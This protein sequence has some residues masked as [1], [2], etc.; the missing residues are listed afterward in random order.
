VS[1]SWTAAGT[2]THGGE[3]SGVQR[4]GAAGAV[5]LV[6]A[7]HSFHDARCPLSAAAAAAVCALFDSHTQAV[8]GDN[9]LLLTPPLPRPSTHTAPPPPPRR[10]PL[11]GCAALDGALPQPAERHHQAGG[12]HHQ[13]RRQP[14]GR[15]HERHLAPQ[16]TRAVLRGGHRPGE[17]RGGQSTSSRGRG[18]GR[19]Y[20]EDCLRGLGVWSNGWQVPGRLGGDAGGVLLS[21]CWWQAPLHPLACRLVSRPCPACVCSLSLVC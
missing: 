4:C 12:Q 14:P 8:P 18:L 6:V 13:L 16:P 15:R 3:S 5:V 20:A 1:S 2:A 11:P 10:R 7:H 21:G 19:C 9:S 17:Q